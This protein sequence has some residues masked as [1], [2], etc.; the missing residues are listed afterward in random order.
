MRAR[1]MS[2]PAATAEGAAQHL[3]DERRPRG[4]SNHQRRR[5]RCEYIRYRTNSHTHSARGS[6]GMVDRCFRLRA[7]AWALHKFVSVVHASH[8]DEGLVDGRCEP[9]AD[10]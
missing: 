5:E 1:Q 8:A 6:D 2:A 3:H 7:L 4:Q 9:L 10:E